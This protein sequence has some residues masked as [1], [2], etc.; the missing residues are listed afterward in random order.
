MACNNCETTFQGSQTIIVSVVKSGTNALLYLQNQGRNIA[1]LQR[2]L[3]CYSTPSG[4]T[5]VL[6][7]R[8]PPTGIAWTYPSAFIEPGLTALY[9]T[10]SGV[11]A[12]STVQAQAEYVELEGRS[13]SCP[14]T[15]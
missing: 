14:T 12:G 9:Y 15:M 7:L 5:T 6:F 2:I 8:P 3:L 1:Q 11:P 4:G 13:R 10:L